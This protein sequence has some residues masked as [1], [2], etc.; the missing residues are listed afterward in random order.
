MFLRIRVKNQLSN[1][2][3]TAEEKTISQG[4]NAKEIRSHEEILRFSAS[5]VC[6]SCELYSLGCSLAL[7][8]QD[9]KCIYVMLTYGIG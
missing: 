6:I 7:W 8:D 9:W 3:T 4:R 2:K 5:T 1:N